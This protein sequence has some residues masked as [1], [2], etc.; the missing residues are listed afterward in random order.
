MQQA[1]YISKLNNIAICIACM[2][3]IKYGMHGYRVIRI[4]NFECQFI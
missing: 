2:L 1:A 3:L 4:F